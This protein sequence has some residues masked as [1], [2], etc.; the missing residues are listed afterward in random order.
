MPYIRVDRLLRAIFAVSLDSLRKRRRQPPSLKYGSGQTSDA[1]A[2][3]TGDESRRDRRGLEKVG[4]AKERDGGAVFRLN[5]CGVRM[6]VGT[7]QC[8]PRIENEGRWLSAAESGCSIRGWR[9]GARGRRE[10]GWDG[11]VGRGNDNYIMAR[12]SVFGRPAKR[13]NRRPPLP[14]SIR[15]VP[16]HDTKA[17]AQPSLSI[18]GPSIA[19]HSCSTSAP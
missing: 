17:H 5:E 11:L 18:T 3:E 10:W 19:C 16:V 1:A 7:G 2:V 9:M 12:A 4:L 6:Y 8:E 13:P 15:E 14:P